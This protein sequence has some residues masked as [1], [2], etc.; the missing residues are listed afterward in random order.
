MGKCYQN[1][2]LDIKE[3]K[4]DSSF[5]LVQVKSILSRFHSIFL[6]YTYRTVH[7][8][9]QALNNWTGVFLAL[10]ALFSL[11]IHS[12]ENIRKLQF[13]INRKYV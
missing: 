12:A 7:S 1:V 2:T 13:Y 6:M 4:E 8:C 11:Y 9:Q 3:L 10:H 5:S